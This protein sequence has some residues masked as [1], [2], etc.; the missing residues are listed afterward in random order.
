[1]E[2]GQVKVVYLKGSYDVI[3]NRMQTR[4]DHYMKPTMLQSQF[5]ALEE[6]QGVITE[7]ITFAPEVILHDIMEQLNEK[8]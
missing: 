7:G 3:L 4:T 8:D 6:P 1:V 2:T 5:D